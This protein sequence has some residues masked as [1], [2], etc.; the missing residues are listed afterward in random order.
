MSRIRT[1]VG[2]FNETAAARVAVEHLLEAGFAPD[3]IN[4]ATADTLRAQ[5]IEV[6]ENE[7]AADSFENNIVRFFMEVFAGDH[8]DAW[9][10]A[11]ATRPNSAV[12][13]VNAASP[14]GAER[15]LTLLDKYGAV[16]VYKQAP[17]RAA[18]P[19]S[20]NASNVNINI[21]RMR[22]DDELDANGLTTH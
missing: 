10:Y 12:V 9:T 4:V 6:P 7:V 13:T 2:L 17:N 8:D 5:N 18:R 3:A 22:D 19:D 1:I 16:D 15:A 14:S 11:K 21:S 20:N